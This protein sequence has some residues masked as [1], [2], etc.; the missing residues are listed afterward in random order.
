MKTPSEILAELKESNPQALLADGFEEA[1][2]GLAERC[3]QPTLAVYDYE[4][5]V[6]VL[7]RSHDLTDNEAR[8]FLDFNTVGAWLGEHTP[9]WLYR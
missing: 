8:E 4:K 5:A 7:V 3:G 2:V 9:L 6:T 1:L